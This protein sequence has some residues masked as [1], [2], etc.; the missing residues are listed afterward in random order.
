MNFQHFRGKSSCECTG[1]Y[2][3]NRMQTQLHESWR[4]KNKNELILDE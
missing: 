3:F 2:F 4:K 1:M